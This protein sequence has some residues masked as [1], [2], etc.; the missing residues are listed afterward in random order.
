MWLDRD[1]LFDVLAMLRKL[2]KFRVVIGGCMAALIT[3][4]VFY[5][6]THPLVFNESFFEHAHCIVITGLSLDSYASEHGGR[7]PVDTNG[8]GNALLQ[9]TNYTANFWAGLTGPGYDG[10]VFEE[11]AQTGGRIPEAQCGRIYVQGLGRTDNPDIALFFDKIPSPGGDHCH[12]PWRL[13]APM[14][15]EVWTVGS[16]R[17]VVPESEW[18]AYSKEQIGL[19]GVAGI[20]RQQAEEYYA[21]TQ[22][23]PPVR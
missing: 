19:L 8:Y 11:A 9:L 12:F 21:E 3:F 14:V 16:G 10:K 17:R 13:Y 4:C 2:K 15:R 18:A 23:R 20:S 6:R 22:E 5:I 1:D 7:Y